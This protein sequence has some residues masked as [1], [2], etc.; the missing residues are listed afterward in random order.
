MYSWGNWKI[1]GQVERIDGVTY[2]F[3][4]KISSVTLTYI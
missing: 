3:E 1:F 2:V 4:L